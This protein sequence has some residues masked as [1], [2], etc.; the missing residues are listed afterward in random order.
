MNSSIVSIFVIRSENTLKNMFESSTI[1]SRFPL[2]KY[3]CY[4]ISWYIWILFPASSVRFAWIFPSHVIFMRST[5]LSI[6]SRGLN[7]M[8]HSVTASSLVISL[9]A[10]ALPLSAF[11]SSFNSSYPLSMGLTTFRVNVFSSE[12]TGTFFIAAIALKEQVRK[13]LLIWFQSF[14]WPNTRAWDMK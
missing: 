12:F 1:Y 10:L 3:C 4:K 13:L 11:W 14:C 8:R 2:H 9:R 7:L 5:R 6:T